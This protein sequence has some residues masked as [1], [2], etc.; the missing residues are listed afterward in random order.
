MPADAPGAII[1]VVGAS[2][3]GKDTLLSGAQERLRDDPA[4]IF[5]R[6]DITRPASPVG[7]QHREVT[8]EEFASLKVSG[9]YAL[10]WH[11]HGN[12]Y[13]ILS[14]ITDMASQGRV[15]IISGSRAALC[16]ARDRFP[17]LSIVHITAPLAG[18]QKRLEQRGREAQPEIEDRI[19]RA[20]AYPVEGPDVHILSNDA[21]V[22]TGVRKFTQLLQSLAQR[23]PNGAK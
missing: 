13:G 5:A 11:A 18:L 9:A 1:Y 12:G 21:D 23:V 3:V 8:Q 2:G 14:L 19:R 17:G 7:E 15:V 20:E 4:F 10:S 6:R 16:E 22:E